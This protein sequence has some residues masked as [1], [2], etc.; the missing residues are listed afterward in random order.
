MLDAAARTMHQ[1][2]AIAERAALV[3]RLSV[4]YRLKGRTSDSQRVILDFLDND[5]ANSERGSENYVKHL[6]L[7][8]ARNRIY[9]FDYDGAYAMVSAWQ[10]PYDG[11]SDN[12][13]DLLIERLLTTGRILKG[14]GWFREAGSCFEGYLKSDKINEQQRR[15]ATAHLS[16]CYC[17][18][19]YAE[20][21]EAQ[22][23]TPQLSY[24][25]RARQLLEGAF[26]RSNVGDEPSYALRHLFLSLTEVDIQQGHLYHAEDRIETLLNLYSE[27]TCGN[28]DDKLGHVRALIAKARISTPDEAEERWNAALRQNAA[29]N[30]AEEEVFTCGVIHLALSVTRCASKHPAQADDSFEKAANVLRTK[31]PRYI[32]PGLGT[33]IFDDIKRRLQEYGVRGT[34]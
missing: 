12:E 23:S 27:R 8:A 20:R 25:S 6:Q 15:R 29:Y 2:N 1:V 10:F 22:E 34:F 24:L 4:L 5:L 21:H 11:M 9:Q 26:R 14:C 32:I 28:I 17:E 19:D 16:D 13:F 3:H 7:S 33:Y 31:T 18:I 30:P